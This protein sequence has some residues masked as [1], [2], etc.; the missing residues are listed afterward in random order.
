MFFEAILRYIDMTQNGTFHVLHATVF[1]YPDI[2]KLT[3]YRKYH[4]SCR[5]S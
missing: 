3:E 4:C 5:T 1:T 2:V